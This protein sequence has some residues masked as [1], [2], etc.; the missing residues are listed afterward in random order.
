MKAVSFIVSLRLN[1]STPPLH[2]SKLIL[3]NSQIITLYHIC[4]PLRREIVSYFIVPNAFAFQMLW[5]G[6]LFLF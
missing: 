2:T 5:I 1:A 3:I 4:T 6:K